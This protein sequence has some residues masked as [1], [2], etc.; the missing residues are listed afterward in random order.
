MM[1][2]ECN[3]CRHWVTKRARI[4]DDG[5]E[6]VD[7]GAEPNCGHCEQLAISTAFNFGCNRYDG[8]CDVHVRIEHIAGAPW[9]R[10]H[11]D[12]CP[13]C[14]GRGSGLQGGVCGRCSGTGRVRFYA[15]G[16]I[17]EEKTRRHP[18]QP[19]QKSEIDPGTPWAPIERADVLKS[20]TL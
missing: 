2:F 4:Y 13:D 8:P 17:G 6:R 1:P 16:F 7:F 12:K 3:S 10:W 5:T 19:E 20:D 15:D 14:A 9:Q 11:M 18:K